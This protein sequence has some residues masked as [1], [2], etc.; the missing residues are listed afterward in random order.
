MI[1]LIIWILCFQLIGFF[2]GIMTQANIPSWYNGLH[3]STLTPPGWVFSLVWSLLYALLAIVGFMLWQ[4]RSKPQIKT[5][6]NLYLV[7]LIMNWAWTPLF[8]H[9][10]WI[11]FSF[12]W[13]LL[14]IGLNAL[15]ILKVK[16]IERVVGLLLT[17]YFLWLIFASYLNGVIWFLNSQV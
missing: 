5:I 3:K 14:M 8:F 2:L 11:G 6:L 16:N 17:P 7:Q 12:L 9:L 15:I 1:K 13:I 4:N 10:H